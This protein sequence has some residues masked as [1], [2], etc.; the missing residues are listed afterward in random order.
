VGNV[1]GAQGK[2]GGFVYDATGPNNFSQSAIWMLG[3]D[4]W[5]PYPYDGQVEATAIRDGNWDWVQAK[6]SWHNAQPATLPASLYLPQN[7]QPPPF[8][9]ANPFPW[10]DPTT[11]KTFTLPAKARFDAGTPNVVP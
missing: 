10:V 9:G 3:W 5:D 1:L 2:M 4:G 11:G 6:Q 7:A 8:F